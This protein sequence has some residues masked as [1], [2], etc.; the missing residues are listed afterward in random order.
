MLPLRTVA[1]LTMGL[2]AAAPAPDPLAPDLELLRSVSVPTD[3]P[4]LL[5]FFRKRTPGES[6]RAKTAALIRQL[7]DEDFFVREKAAE[8]LIAIGPVAG[9]LL[10]DATKDPDVEVAR[11]AEHCLAK[12]EKAGGPA[13]MAAA[14]RVLAQRKPEQATEVLL[15]Y[16]PNA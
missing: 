9:P 7:A 15:A 8:T 6:D 4:G 1:L 10:R 12:I 16:L 13:C 11:R 3:G 5:E 2:L 14:A